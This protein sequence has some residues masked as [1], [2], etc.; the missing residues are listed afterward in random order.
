MSGILDWLESLPVAALYGCLAIIAAIENIF[1]PVPAD[2]VVQPPALL[3]WVYA[4]FDGMLA[5]DTGTGAL[6][7]SLASVAHACMASRRSAR[8][9]KDTSQVAL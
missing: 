6:L 2:T 4:V 7:I 1:P 5:V 9:L 3:H 8:S